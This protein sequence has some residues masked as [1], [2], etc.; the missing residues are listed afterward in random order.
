MWAFLP[1]RA[2]PGS[3]WGASWRQLPS[4]RVLSLPPL[5]V[6]WGRPYGGR[7]WEPWWWQR[8]TGSSCSSF[9]W[10]QP[11]WETQAEP[12]GGDRGRQMSCFTVSDF[13]ELKTFPCLQC[14]K[15]KEA[16]VYSKVNHHSDG[17]IRNTSAEKYVN[18]EWVSA[19]ST[20]VKVISSGGFCAPGCYK[21]SWL[22]TCVGESES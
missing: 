8:P 19:A 5:S 18:A 14:Q 12:E 3:G 2:G 1:S 17:I 4:L 21:R 22:H 7:G 13:L 9:P 10:K 11:Y 20:E 16:S 6:C 15:Q